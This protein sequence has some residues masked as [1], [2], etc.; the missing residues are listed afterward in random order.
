MQTICKICKGSD[1]LC[2]GCQQRLDAGEIN[3]QDVHL[4]RAISRLSER[5]PALSRADFKKTLNVKDLSVVIV[6]KGMAGQFIGKG[7][8]FIKELSKD[9]GKRLKVVEETTNSKELVQKIIF[10]AKLLGVNVVYNSNKK[11]SYRVRVP[12]TD[13]NK[14]YDQKVLEEL[15]AGLLEGETSIIFE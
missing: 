2:S 15:F 7:G 4:A 13:R 10:P 8:V 9:V 11:E 12:R 5:Y 6:P 3:E 1:I 14:I